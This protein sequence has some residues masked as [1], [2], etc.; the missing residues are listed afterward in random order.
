VSLFA[1]Q[2]A[3]LPEM[4]AVDAIEG[5]TREYVRNLLSML[6]PSFIE[7]GQR[8]AITQLGDPKVDVLLAALDELDTGDVG[9]VAE[10][11]LAEA[12]KAMPHPD[13]NSRIFLM[14]GDGESNVL[15]NQMNGVLGFSLGAQ[16]TMVFVWPV[17]NWQTWLEYT[18]VHEYAHLV[19]NLL[20]PRGISGGKLVYM[21][22]KE[23]ETLLDAMIAEGIADAFALS[24]TSKVVPSWTDALNPEETEHIW[25]RV[26]RRLAV[27]DTTDIRRMLFGD[28]DR[29]PQWA[30]YTLGY[31]MVQS[32]LEKRPETTFSEIVKLP[33][34]EILAGSSYAADA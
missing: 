3:A 12:V 13:L 16:A 30:G 10:S 20:F 18:I 8:S 5:Q 19:R 23:P 29:V 24:V 2:S 33:G 15:V 17:E 25:P 34:S 14:P 7:M 4:E 31:R 32:Y 26:R 1:R 11:A 27:S 28:N 9:S 21:N 6:H 22:T